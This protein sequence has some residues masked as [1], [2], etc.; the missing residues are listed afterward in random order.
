MC[1]TYTADALSREILFMKQLKGNLAIHLPRRVEMGVS[2][3]KQVVQIE[4]KAIISEIRQVKRSW[5]CRRSH[6]LRIL[7]LGVIK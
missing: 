7:E 1:V 6:L 2:V 5:E 3:S 4:D